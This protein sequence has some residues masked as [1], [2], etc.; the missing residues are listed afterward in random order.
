MGITLSRYENGN[1]GIY[2]ASQ[3]S[4]LEYAAGVLL[5]ENPGML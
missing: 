1:I 5:K 4:D 2:S 3:L